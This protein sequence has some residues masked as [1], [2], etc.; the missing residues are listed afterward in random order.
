MTFL[1]AVA[2]FFGGF[3][4]CFGF[5]LATQK[6]IIYKWEWKD[7]DK[8]PLDDTRDF[9]LLLV[10][11]GKEVDSAYLAS[12]NYDANGK[13]IWDYNKKVITHWAYLPS[14]PIKE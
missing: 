6:P 13:R 2:S 7:I 14:P 8:Y 10:T 12:I 11:D 3:I 4:I 9:K 1:T 5:R